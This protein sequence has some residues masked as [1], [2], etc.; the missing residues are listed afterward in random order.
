MSSD[1][2]LSEFQRASDMD[3]GPEHSTKHEVTE[4][5]EEHGAGVLWEESNPWDHPTFEI[6]RDGSGGT[7]DLVVLLDGKTFVVEYKTGDSVGQVYDSRTQLLGYWL[8]HVQTEQRYMAGGTELRID[9]F[10]TATSHSHAGRL[11]PRY[12]EKR[13]DHLDM[14]ETRQKV[15]EIGQLPPAEYRMTE[16][17]IRALWRDVKLFGDTLGIEDPAGS[18]TPHVGSLL[19]DA[20]VE[21][22]KDPHPAVL[23]N[24]SRHN[25]CWEVLS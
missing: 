3:A 6:E 8:E 4:W 16:Q 7:P 2:S 5:L 17:H 13:Q 11:F 12:A 10:L 9:G 15:Y 18:E 22:S 14:D 21:P 20:L 25:Q 23:W 24:K 19:S 1:A